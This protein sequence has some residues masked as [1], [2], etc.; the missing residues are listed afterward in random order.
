M[1]CAVLA[2]FMAFLLRIVAAP[3]TP[4]GI[5]KEILSPLLDP[6]KVATLKGSRPSNETS[7]IG[8]VSQSQTNTRDE[9]AELLNVGTAADLSGADIVASLLQVSIRKYPKK[10]DTGCH[11]LLVSANHCCP[12]I[13]RNG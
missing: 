13:S 9:A 2:C 12:L 6:A 10:V 1:F 4:A 11:L 7:P 5:A 8:G 3:K